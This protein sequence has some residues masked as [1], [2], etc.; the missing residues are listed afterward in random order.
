MG[1][2]VGF[3]CGK[4]NEGIF[5]VDF[6]VDSPENVVDDWEGSFEIFDESVDPAVL[7]KTVKGSCVGKETLHTFLR[8]RYRPGVAFW[9]L[10]P[11][12]DQT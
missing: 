11:P 10:P 4:E 5:C 8:R 2:V 9:F 7:F 3:P 6:D 1:G 12:L